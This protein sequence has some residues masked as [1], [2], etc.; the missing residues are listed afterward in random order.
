MCRILIH[1]FCL[2]WS[3]YFTALKLLFYFSK[4]HS[5]WTASLAVTI[6]KALIAVY[7]QSESICRSFP[8]FFADYSEVTGLS[9]EPKNVKGENIQVNSSTSQQAV[10]TEPAQI[11]GFGGGFIA[12]LFLPHRNCGEQRRIVKSL[13]LV[14]KTGQTP[15]SV[16]ALIPP[17][18]LSSAWDLLNEDLGSSINY[19]V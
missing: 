14:A 2:R 12:L 18:C 15:A 6:G 8:V 5:R 9:W 3:R 1:C 16:S 4:N 17:A 11:I 7:N 13:S 10:S 19:V